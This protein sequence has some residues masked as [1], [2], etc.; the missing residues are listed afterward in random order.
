M[1][2]EKKESKSMKIVANINYIQDSFNKK[3]F[4][5]KEIVQKCKTLSVPYPCDI[6]KGLIN[7]NKIE[8][9]GKGQFK[10]K[11]DRP[12]YHFIIEE[13]LK[14]AQTKHAKY[15]SNHKQKKTSNKKE[16]LKEEPKETTTN[17]LGE[18]IDINRFL[19]G[20][21]SGTSAETKSAEQVLSDKINSIIYQDPLSIAIDY[22]KS[23]GLRVS[24]KVITWE[25][26]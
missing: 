8:K 4:N 17:S 3:C 25:D 22:V 5:T 26:L 16:P 15:Q 7:K 14:E 6:L 19:S 9:V 12:I 24:R 11:N 20:A 10:F 13:L 18:L 1:K 2:K 21:S 23:N